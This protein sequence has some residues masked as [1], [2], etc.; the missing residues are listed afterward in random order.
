M[1]HCYILDQLS[2]YYL[3]HHTITPVCVCRDASAAVVCFAVNDAASWERL[4][5]WVSEL[6]QEEAA[7]RIYV[8]ATKVDLLQVRR[9]VQQQLVIIINNCS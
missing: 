5:F 4:K 9:N 1:L 3:L 2:V 7:C 6:R 8:A